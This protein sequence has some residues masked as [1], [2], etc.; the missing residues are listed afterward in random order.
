MK[1]LKRMSIYDIMDDDR[2]VSFANDVEFMQE[3]DIE[4]DILINEHNIRPVIA[5]KIAY[6]ITYMKM[7][8]LIPT[9][10][11]FKSGHVNAVTY[12]G[13]ISKDGMYA[14][15]TFDL[16]N[17]T[18]Q[19][20][21]M[22]KHNKLKKFT[23]TPFSGSIGEYILMLISEWHNDEKISAGRVLLFIKEYTAVDEILFGG[24]TL[25]LKALISLLV[26]VARGWC[27]L[28]PTNQYATLM[29][30]DEVM[31][32]EGLLER[33]VSEHDAVYAQKE[34]HRLLKKY[35]IS[36]IEP[37]IVPDNDRYYIQIPNMLIKIIQ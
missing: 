8:K 19:I 14:D 37:I 27:K 22:Q 21:I 36:E 30:F 1:T 3:V 13:D 20:T 29:P 25:T 33:Y 2:Y 6:L 28:V 4:K 18:R 11:A 32:P 35:G 26:R 34:I 12:S 10:F 17:K 9:H 15:I 23:C 16:T 24:S 31:Y 5:E 7:H